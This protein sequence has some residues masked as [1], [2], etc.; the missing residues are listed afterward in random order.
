MSALECFN[1]ECKKLF[2]FD[3]L[4]NLKVTPSSEFV[5][6]EDVIVCIDQKCPRCKRHNIIHNRVLETTG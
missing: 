1:K 2:S 5:K 4:N 6:T 3:E